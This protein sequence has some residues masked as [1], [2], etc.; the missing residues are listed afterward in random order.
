MIPIGVALTVPEGTVP[1]A[2]LDVDEGRELGTI[3]LADR[4]IVVRALSRLRVL[5]IRYS[6]GR[7][8]L[9][10]LEMAGEILE[11]EAAQ[12]AAMASPVDET[13]G[14]HDDR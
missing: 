2:L 9:S 1:G 6:D 5:E 8:P 3:V 14:G 7:D 12:R 10:V 13:D 11:R 4:T